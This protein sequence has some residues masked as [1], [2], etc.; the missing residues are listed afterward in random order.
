MAALAIPRA[1]HRQRTAQAVMAQR[2]QP[3]SVLAVPAPVTGW[4]ARDSLDAMAVTDAIRLDNWMPLLGSVDVRPGYSSH[5]TGV[6]SGSVE[7]LAEYN[8]GGTRKPLAAG[9]GA[10]YDA[11]STGAVGGSLL[12]SQTS[13]QW[14]TT[15]LGDLQVWVNGTDGEQTFDGTVFAGLTFT[16][17]DRPTAGTVIVAH[18]H[19]RRVYYAVNA[20]GVGFGDEGDF[21]YSSLDGSVTAM[22]V[23]QL[24]QVLPRGGSLVNIMTVSRDAGQGTDD[25]IAFVLSSGQAAIYTGENPDDAGWALVGLFDLG[26]PI[27]PRMAA[28]VGAD[29]VIGGQD[30][31]NSLTGVL[32]SSRS[33]PDTLLS[34]KITD[35]VRDAL[36]AVAANRFGWQMIHYPR[37][38]WLIV[39]HPTAGADTYEQHVLN[40]VTGAW[41]RWRAINARSWSLFQD[42]PYFGAGA[43]IVYRFDDG[44]R[45]DAG[46]R[47]IAE[48]H[49]AFNH[50]GNRAGQVKMSSIRPGIRTS[51]EVGLTLTTARDFQPHQTAI[52][53]TVVGQGAGTTP[54]SSPWGSPWSSGQ[55]AAAPWIGQGGVG[56][57]FSTRFRVATDQSVA[58]DNLTFNLVPVGA[59]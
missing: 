49:T 28:K 25:Y 45:T 40:L 15:H 37:R 18:V 56:Y 12:G 26:G 53:E 14:I 52:I 7:T 59:W 41:C 5:A 19:K 55:I 2:A 31:Y 36:D 54:W 30:G 42:R 39:N 46:M 57:T 13:N 24:S 9:G 34:H 33:D 1:L 35:A 29:A 21:F 27:S 43:G 16:G 17:T 20:P 38:G 44:S 58:L 32:R 11:T 22:K 23:F 51:G 48:G 47:I 6:G 8:S 4:N 3:P 10:I 50:F